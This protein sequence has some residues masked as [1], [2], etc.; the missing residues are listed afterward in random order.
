MIVF[1]NVPLWE[2]RK[3]NISWHNNFIA[4]NFSSESFKVFIAHFVLFVFNEIVSKYF[5]VSDKLVSGRWITDTFKKLYAFFSFQIFEFSEL[6]QKHKFS[7]WHIFSLLHTVKFLIEC[8]LLFGRL[9]L[10]L[11]ET[12]F[13]DLLQ[14]LRKASRWPSAFVREQCPP[15][16]FYHVI[17]PR[18]LVQILT[19]ISLRV[20]ISLVKLKIVLL[21]VQ[22]LRLGTSHNTN[23]LRVKIELRGLDLKLCFSRREWLR[24]V[25]KRQLG[26]SIPLYFSS[27][28]SNSDI[29]MWFEFFNWVLKIDWAVTFNINML[30]ISLSNFAA[31]SHINIFRNELV[32]F[33]VN[34]WISMN[35]YQ[36]FVSFTV[37]TNTVIEVLELISWS[38]LDVDVFA[39][40]GGNHALFTILYLEESCCRWQNVEALRSW[41]VVH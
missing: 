23:S 5:H 12:R 26:V 9:G 1:I 15:F 2:S 37:N 27:W 7:C 32:F 3:G 8:V 22:S 36:Y 21:V 25:S 31:T 35:R 6:L 33:W 16:A 41:R 38:E 11:L 14:L 19:C 13:W 28:W 4:I 18:R 20:L 24:I 17:W 30:H 34:Y 29:R 10:G 39:D 40:T